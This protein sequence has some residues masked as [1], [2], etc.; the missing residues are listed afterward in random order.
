M[1]NKRTFWT[2][3][4]WGAAF[5]CIANQVVRRGLGGRRRLGLVKR[6]SNADILKLPAR[7]LPLQGEQGDPADRVP[8]RGAAR[9]VFERR[10][11][12]AGKRR[13]VEAGEVP[14]GSIERPDHG[15]VSPPL[16]SASPP[17][18]DR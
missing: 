15:D 18:V 2:G 6:S 14:G 9:P 13:A 1:A 4:L 12:T 7:E 3:A 10:G 8:Q 5:A 16:R 11:G 17:A